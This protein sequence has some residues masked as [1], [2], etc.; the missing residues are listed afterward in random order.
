MTESQRPKASRDSLSRVLIDWA[1]G[2]AELAPV[3][4]RLRISLL[5]M[6]F[7]IPAVILA[8]AFSVLAIRVANA[9]RFLFERLPAAGI[10]VNFL[11]ALAGGFVAYGLVAERALRSGRPSVRGHLWRAWPL[12]GGAIFLGT[13]FVT[14]WRSP[15]FGLVAQLVLWPALAFVGGIIA[16]LVVGR[17]RGR[18]AAEPSNV[19]NPRKDRS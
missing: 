18:Y 19:T 16:D 8:V 6:I 1:P 9:L 15:G 5:Y 11:P 2:L 10:F 3:G 17:K 14:G 4:R 12:Y 13:A 7:G